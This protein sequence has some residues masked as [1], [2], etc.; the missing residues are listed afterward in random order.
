MMLIVNFWLAQRSDG[1]ATSGK[2]L[3]PFEQMIIENGCHV[4][5]TKVLLSSS[6]DNACHLF[7]YIQLLV[8]L[9]LSF[10]ETTVLKLIVPCLWTKLWKNCCFVKIHDSCPFTIL[11]SLSF[12]FYK[13]A[14]LRLL[15][16]WNNIMTVLAVYEESTY[17]H[18]VSNFCPRWH[19]NLVSQTGRRRINLW[20]FYCRD[21]LPYFYARTES[22]R[23]VSFGKYLAADLLPG[24]KL[25]PSVISLQ[26]P[27]L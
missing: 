1:L 15:I 7:C 4:I 27:R 14:S 11:N 12:F 26:V 9:M 5:G 3:L 2:T 13:K 17:V 10:Q 18:G 24:G 22:P 16:H 20:L 19:P 23:S 8:D 6:Q 25:V 21:Q